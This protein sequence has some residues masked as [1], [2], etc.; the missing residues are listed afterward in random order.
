MSSD[1]SPIKGRLRAYSASK[2]QQ[3]PNLGSNEKGKARL[4]GSET[5]LTPV[6]LEGVQILETEPQENTLQAGTTM[7][8]EL[9]DSKEPKNKMDKL[10]EMLT[11]LTT[12]VNAIQ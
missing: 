12:S 8:R 10:E 4:Q 1:L 5:D 3:T 6:L 2:V 9:R 11:T 7:A